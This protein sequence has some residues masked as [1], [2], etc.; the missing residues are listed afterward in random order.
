[1]ALN[2]PVMATSKADPG[3]VRRGL[4]MMQQKADPG[5]VWLSGLNDAMTGNN[6]SANVAVGNQVIRERRN[7]ARNEAVGGRPGQIGGYDDT[8]RQIGHSE[9]QDGSSWGDFFAALIGKERINAQQGRKTNIDMSGFG[10]L[11]AQDV[12]TGKVYDTAGGEV[13]PGM[14][15]PAPEWAQ[16]QQGLQGGSKGWYTPDEWSGMGQLSQSRVR[17]S[18]F[19]R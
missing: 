2:Y 18:M 11:K 17:G 12:P 6:L 4:G 3:G 1:M 9:A 13:A 19:N 5:A 15:G 8:M 16:A 7:K 10:R 14:R